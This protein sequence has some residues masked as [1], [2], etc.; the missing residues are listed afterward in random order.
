M[1]KDKLEQLLNLIT[2]L[3]DENKPYAEKRREVLIECSEHDRTNL[4]E[5]AS[6]F[7]EIV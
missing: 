7:E 2:E 4:Q 1:S 3:V 6:W 5:F